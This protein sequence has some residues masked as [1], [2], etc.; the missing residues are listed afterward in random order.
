MKRLLLIS[1]AIP[2]VTHAF[3]HCVKEWS[4]S[5][6]KRDERKDMPNCNE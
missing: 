4:K 5:M 2:I 6:K 3:T 1:V